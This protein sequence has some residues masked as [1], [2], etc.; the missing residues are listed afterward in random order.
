MKAKNDVPLSGDT[1]SNV[2]GQVLDNQIDPI[3]ERRVVRKL[4]L[5]I[6]PVCFIVYLSCFIDRANIGMSHTQCLDAVEAWLTSRATG[7]VKVAGMPKEIGATVQQFS[8]A[9]SIFYATYV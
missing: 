6:T 5:F 2:E 7:N 1:S 8:T 9:V 4:D 3:K